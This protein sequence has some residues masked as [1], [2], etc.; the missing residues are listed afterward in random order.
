M[1]NNNIQHLTVLE[2]VH[3]RD[4][5]RNR[6]FYRCLCFCGNIKTVRK[7][8]YVR[9][10]VTSCGCL[11]NTLIK[12][13]LIKEIK[14]GTEYGFLTVVNRTDIKSTEGY[15]YICKCS[16][17]NSLA[18][19]AN[20]LKRGETKS[21]GCSS[22]KLNSLNNGGTG[23]PY[24]LLELSKTIRVCKEYKNFVASCLSRSN[25]RSE[26][27]GKMDEILHVHHINSVSFLIRNY[28]LNKENY[29]F[30]SELFSPDNAIVLTESEHRLF[31]SKY[32]KSSSKTDWLLFINEV[33]K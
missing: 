21:C 18:V 33:I 3:K 2:A 28:N 27:S 22:N 32:G 14:V 29:L 9:N 16:C 26:I 17:G 31:H 11:T 6:L 24:E 19:Y 8:D 15:K 30:C 10:F 13:K 20:R 12:T 1:S 23:I 25:M 5:T 4:A 7:S